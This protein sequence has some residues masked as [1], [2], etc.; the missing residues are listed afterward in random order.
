M[1]IASYV[2][3]ALFG[4]ISIVNLYFAFTEKDKYR[5]ITKPFCLTFLI[6]AAILYKPTSPYIYIGAIF[7]LIG[8]IFFIWPSKKGFFLYGIIAFLIGHIFYLIQ[9]ILSLEGNPITNV[10]Y[11]VSSVIFVIVAV[12]LF[13]IAKKIT[14]NIIIATACSIYGPT[15]ILLFVASIFLACNNANHIPG[16]MA[17]IGYFFF[18][19]SD[20]TILYTSF[21][22]KGVKRRHFYIM[23]TYLLAQLL[24]VLGFLLI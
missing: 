11:I 23:L 10:G 12:C 2:F 15:L 3:F 9:I 1:L 4:A 16:V 5:K 7:G 22:N 19:V 20:S 24:I 17:S 14:K 13:P 18:I 6:I 21:V 8:D